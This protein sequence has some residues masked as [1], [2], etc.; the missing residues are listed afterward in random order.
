MLGVGLHMATC[1]ES[2]NKADL[3]VGRGEEAGLPKV[4]YL[5]VFP[6]KPWGC[7]ESL[8]HRPGTA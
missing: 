6:A 3:G 7:P 4:P 8:S 2:R 5:E 1:L